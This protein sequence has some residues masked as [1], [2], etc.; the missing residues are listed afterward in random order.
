MVELFCVPCHLMFDS[1]FKG[2]A[3]VTRC[4]YRIT[5]RLTEG[6]LYHLDVGYIADVSDIPAA[7][8]LKG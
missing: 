2:M 7:S 3:S 8:V 6:R 4:F 1:R 5:K